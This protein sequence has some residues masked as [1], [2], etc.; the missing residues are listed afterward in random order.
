V[1][2]RGLPFHWTCEV[3]LKLFPLTVSVN[4]ALPAG[5]DAGVI[6]LVAGTGLGAT[7]VNA[8]ALDVPPP[9]AGVT[10]VTLALP[11]VAISAATIVVLSVVAET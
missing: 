1:V 5:A 8:W 7:I 4:P 11:A 10:T 9:G 6:P 2:V 3:L